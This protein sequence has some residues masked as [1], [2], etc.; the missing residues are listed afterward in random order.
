MKYLAVLVFA[1][2]CVAAL[3]ASGKKRDGNSPFAGV[4][5]NTYNGSM[6]SF[7][8]DEDGKPTSDIIDLNLQHFQAMTISRLPA[9]RSSPPPTYAP[10]TRW[11]LS[12]RMTAS[13]SVRHART[14]DPRVS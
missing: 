5:E 11:A 12:L 6:I 7:F 2:L 8:Y 9:T 10:R 4:T 1:T 3:A 13:A 14:H